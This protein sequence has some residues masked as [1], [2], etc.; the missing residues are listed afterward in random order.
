VE[1][2]EFSNACGRGGAD[3]CLLRDNGIDDFFCNEADGD[4]LDFR[5]SSAPEFLMA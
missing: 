5:D 4:L 1:P 3:F 2:N